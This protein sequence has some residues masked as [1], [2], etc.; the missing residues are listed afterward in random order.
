[1]AV[2]A[3][4]EIPTKGIRSGDLFG[5]WEL[6]NSDEGAAL[7]CPR[8][9]DKSVQIFGEFDGATVKLVATNDKTLQNWQDAYDYEGVTISQTADRKPWVILPNVYAI[10]PIIE[11]PGPNT[12]VTVAVVAKGA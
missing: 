2:K 4:I 5:E 3:F 6:E 12:S 1:M 8:Y 9:S 10:K 11:N 7:I